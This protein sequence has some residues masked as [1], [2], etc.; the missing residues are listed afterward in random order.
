MKFI[1]LPPRTSGTRPPGLSC[2]KA[3]PWGW[4]TL[5]LAWCLLLPAPG[6]GGEVIIEGLDKALSEAVLA[7]IGIAAEQDNRRLSPARLQALHARAPE[8]IRRALQPFGYYRPRIEASLV[9]SPQDDRKDWRATY[10]IQTGDPVRIRKLNLDMVGEGAADRLLQKARRRFPLKEGE[11]FEHARYEA[12]K[13]RFLQ[14]ALSLGYINA[15]YAIHEARV[16]PEEGAA[17][18]KLVLATGIRYQFGPIIFTDSVLDPALLARYS[19]IREGEPYS[20]RRLLELQNALFGTDYFSRVEITPQLE[21]VAGRRVPVVVDLAP[22]KRH[23]YSAGL[24]YGTDTGLRGSLGYTNRRIN[25]RGHR[26]RTT[27]RFSQLEENFT[28]SYLIPFRNPRRDKWE[29]SASFVNDHPDADR[30]ENSYILTVSRSVGRGRHWMETLRLRYRRDSFLVG[31]RR[32]DSKLLL[33]GF[34]LAWIRGDQDRFRIRRGGRLSMDLQAAH[35]KLFSDTS[36]LQPRLGVKFILPA[37]LQ[38][39]RILLRGEVATTFIDRFD[40]LPPSLRYFTGGDNSVR[41]YAYE[42]LSP[43]NEKGERIGGRHEL[44]GSIELDH[45]FREKWS[46]AIFWDF[47]NAFDDWSAP[48]IEQGAGFGIRW[49]SPLGPLRIDLAEAVSRP[50]RD[51]RLHLVFGPEL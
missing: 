21:D 49:L 15:R 40:R 51:F 25:R 50:G 20:A 32:G 1:T 18:I 28:A 8:E 16:Y 4:A 23:R 12:A 46:A 47:G 37:G 26:L 24:G 34:H 33:P 44:G 5:L 31:S 2:R 42:S 3:L 10:V 17:D 35:E 19:D 36:L 30:E 6:Q 9:Q 29:L 45:R 48:E 13:R 38:R 7:S 22:R 27:L 43:R 14:Q 11:V 41:G 39:S